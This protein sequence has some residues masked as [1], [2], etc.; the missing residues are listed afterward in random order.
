[1]LNVLTAVIT[2]GAAIAALLNPAAVAPGGVIGEGT[3]FFADL[4]AVR[5][6]TVSA[7]VIVFLLVRRAEWA[8]PV[9]VV[10]GLL[11]VGDIGIGIA[12]GNPGLAV[13]AAASAVIHLGTALWLLLRSHR[14][15]AAATTSSTAAP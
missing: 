11:Q 12:H 15:Q 3:D 5:G 13:G 10:A 2:G 1:M 14:A 4:Y 6:I 9:L 8:V 7:A